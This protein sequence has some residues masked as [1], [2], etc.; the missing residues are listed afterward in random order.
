MRGGGRSLNGIRYPSRR[1]DTTQGSAP[2]A[3]H[4]RQWCARHPPT[5]PEGATESV[6]VFSGPFALVTGVAGTASGSGKGPAVVAALIRLVSCLRVSLVV[7]TWRLLLTESQ[8]RT[9]RCV[10]RTVGGVGPA[11]ALCWSLRN[12][13]SV[14][15]LVDE[16]IIGGCASRIQERGGEDSRGGW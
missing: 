1:T 11:V 10:S 14:Q 5:R 12:M 7:V 4:C 6:G 8:R 3:D 15:G 9:S 16:G 2:M 13:G